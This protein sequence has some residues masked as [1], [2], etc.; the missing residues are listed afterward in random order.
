MDYLL[1]GYKW[2]LLSSDPITIG[3][4]LEPWFQSIANGESP[5]LGLS[6]KG[7]L[8]CPGRR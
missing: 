6:S 1:I 2:A 8:Y 7:F 4:D 3:S 5:C